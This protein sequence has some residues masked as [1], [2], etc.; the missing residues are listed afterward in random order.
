M[1]VYFTPNQGTEA[2]FVPE[3]VWETLAKA[4]SDT[5][6]SVH[7]LGRLLTW[8]GV[9][10]STGAKDFHCLLFHSVSGFLSPFQNEELV[11]SLETWPIG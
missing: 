5:S 11:P 6:G 4:A 10:Q 1:S 2:K 8:M 9:L 3:V 7:L